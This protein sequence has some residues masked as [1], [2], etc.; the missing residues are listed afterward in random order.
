MSNLSQFFATGGNKIKKIQR[1]QAVQSTI[2]T[3]LGVTASITSVDM[4][5]TIVVYNNTASNYVLI[6]GQTGVA[7]AGIMGHYAYLYSATEVR[8][9]GT[10]VPVTYATLRTAATI[11]AQIIE[12]E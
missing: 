1:V 4:S 11:E 2:G 7:V 5:K 3:W 6:S 10:S 9:D 12:F 8:F